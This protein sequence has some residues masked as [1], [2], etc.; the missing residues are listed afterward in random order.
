MTLQGSAKELVERG[1]S[2]VV[3]ARGNGPED[4]CVLGFAL[5]GMTAIPLTHDGS[6]GVLRPVPVELVDGDDVGEVEHVDLLQLGRSAE[7]GRHDVERDVGDVHDRGVTLADPRGLHD[8]EVVAS[9]AARADDGGDGVG[10]LG[11]AAARGE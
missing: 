2:R 7:L 11:V 9:G 1:C 6:K 3:E 4:R 5:R 10:D 8:D